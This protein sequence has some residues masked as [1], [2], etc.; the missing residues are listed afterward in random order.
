VDRILPHWLLTGRLSRSEENTEETTMT[1][2]GNKDFVKRTWET[3]LGGNV[4]AA[5]ANFSDDITWFLTGKLDGVSGLK[6][7]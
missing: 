4:E 6:E 2:E 7:R 1:I 5:L 3:L